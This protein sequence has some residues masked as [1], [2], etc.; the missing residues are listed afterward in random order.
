MLQQPPLMPPRATHD[1]HGTQAQETQL[2]LGLNTFRAAP[3]GNE[4]L[5]M[6]AV[7]GPELMIQCSQPFTLPWV[8]KSGLLIYILIWS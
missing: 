4:I 8:M 3:A 2:S 5:E 6:Q 7:T 1:G